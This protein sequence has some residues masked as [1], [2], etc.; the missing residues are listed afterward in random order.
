MLLLGY[1][2]CNGYSVAVAGSKKRGQQGSSGESQPPRCRHAKLGTGRWM[3]REGIQGIVTRGNLNILGSV[4]GY[5]ILGWNRN[6]IILDS[7]IMSNQSK[8]N[9]KLIRLFFGDSHHLLMNIPS[10]QPVERDD[11]QRVLTAAHM[12]PWWSPKIAWTGWLSHLDVV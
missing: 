4:L 5:S 10:N 1:Y 6:W 8:S 9:P 7:L 3:N 11:E 12:A 2:S